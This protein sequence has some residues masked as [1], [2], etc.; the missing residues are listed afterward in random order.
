VHHFPG[1]SR[2]LKVLYD[3]AEFAVVERAARSAGLRPSGYVA[4]AALTAA[5]G[6]SVSAQPEV[7]GRE[8]LEELLRLR[9][10]VRRYGVNV[11]QIAA[12]MNAGGTE[13]PVWLRQV[14][15]RG[16]RTLAAIDEVTGRLSRRLP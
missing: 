10:E 5:Q 3:E 6:G 7:A 16:T 2:A 8:L 13:P 9:L 12:A 11:N 15:D 4:T 14:A 1:R